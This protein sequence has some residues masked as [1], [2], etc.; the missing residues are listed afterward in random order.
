MEEKRKTNN[1]DKKKGKEENDKTT[2]CLL[3]LNTFVVRSCNSLNNF[4]GKG[5]R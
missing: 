5:S 4:A 2:Q 1:R 3:F